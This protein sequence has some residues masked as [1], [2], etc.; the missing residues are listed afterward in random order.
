MKPSPTPK[1]QSRTRREQGIALV[2]VLAIL[3]LTAILVIAFFS[4]ARSEL[5]SS[6][7]Y[8]RGI[9]ASN[10]AKT[11]VDMVIHQIRSS[12]E[13]KGVAWASQPGMIRTWETTPKAGGNQCFKLYS[14]DK[15][16]IPE[17]D[18]FDDVGELKNWQN[19][20]RFV[21][22]NAPVIRTYDTKTEYFYPIID[23]RAA[24]GNTK[25]EGF[26]VDFSAVN[27][28]SNGKALPMPVRWIYQL[29]DGTLGTLAGSGKTGTFQP[30]QI[31]G[32]SLGG[33]PPSSQNPIVA[34]FAFWADDETCK[35]NVNTAAGG[36]AWDTPRAGG[37]SDRA[38]GMFQPVA[39]EFQRYPGHPATTSLIHVLFPGI[40]L[41]NS[42]R[43]DRTSAEAFYDLVPR[44]QR[45]GSV[46]GGYAGTDNRYGLILPI[47]PDQD[48]LYATIDEFI[49]R[50]PQAGMSD[51]KTGG[52]FKRQEQR[53]VGTWPDLRPQ[54]LSRFQFFLT[55]TS[56]APEVTIFNT[57]RISV[58]PS[59][60]GDPTSSTEPHFTTYD[61]RLRFCAEVGKRSA[62]APSDVRAPRDQSGRTPAMY[63]FQRF[64]SASTTADY[65]KIPRNQELYA[66][67]QVLMSSTVPGLDVSDGVTNFN[68]FKNKYGDRNRD[69]IITEIFD[70]IR[71][72]N[73]FDDLLM[74]Q[75]QLK[76]A[77]IP[78]APIAFRANKYYGYWAPAS[79]NDGTHESYTPGR[80]GVFQPEDLVNGHASSV[81]A[82]T[83]S[84]HGQVAPI[85]IASSAGQVT[86][87]FGRFFCFK[88]VGIAIIACAKDDGQAGGLARKAEGVLN[89]G[90]QVE[91][92]RT[93]DGATG[94]GDSPKPGW[95]LSN[96]CPLAAASPEAVIAAYGGFLKPN[97]AGP[98]QLS[99]L[100][101]ASTIVRN[102]PDMTGKEFYDY[103]SQPG[104]WNRSLEVGKPL[105]GGAMK[106]QAALLVS[107]FCP[108]KGWTL[109]NPDFRLRIDVK[110]PF[111]LDGKDLGIPTGP[112]L[113]KSTHVGLGG[114]RIWGGRNQGGILEP[115]M[116]MAGHCK[117]RNPG[118]VDRLAYSWMPRYAP[119][120]AALVEGGG[121]ICLDDPS[122]IF[123][124]NM[125]DPEEGPEALVYPWIGTPILIEGGKTDMALEGASLDL[126]IYPDG[127]ARTDGDDP[128][129]GRVGVENSG[130][131][132]YSQRLQLKFEDTKVPLPI[133]AGAAGGNRRE[134]PS[135]GMWKV[136]E[137]S[138]ARPARFWCWNRDGAFKGAP[139]Q[140]SY[141]WAQ[142]G[143]LS[144]IGNYQNTG[145]T[146]VADFADDGANIVRGCDVVR[147][148]LNAQGDDRLI[149]ATR[150]L[151]EKQFVHYRRSQNSEDGGYHDSGRLVA[152]NFSVESSNSGYGR[153]VK[154]PGI[155]GT[156]PPVR[157]SFVPDANPPASRRPQLPDQFDYKSDQWGDWDNGI[158]AELDGP[159]IN[160]P[161][162][163]NA[164]GVAYSDYEPKP[165]LT[166]SKKRP[167]IP[168]FT[169]SYV[170]ESAGPG[171]WSPNRIMP[172]PGMFGSLPTGV[173]PKSGTDPQPWQTLLFRRIGGSAQQSAKGESPRTGKV[174][175][176]WQHPRDHY[177]LD[178]FWMPVVEPYSISE[179]LATAGKVNMNYAIQPFDYI[180]RKSSLAGVFAS[181]ELL[182]VPNKLAFSAP[183]NTYKDGEGYGGNPTYDRTTD[184]GGNLRTISLRTWISLDETLRQFDNLFG[185]PRGNKPGQIFRTASQICE[186]WLVPGKPVQG[187]PYG[188]L[189]SLKLED[190]SQWY[191]ADKNPVAG[192]RSFGLVG[193]NARERP[194]TNLVA[195]LT[196]KSNTFNVHYRA[197]IIRQSPLSPTAPGQR[198]ADQEFAIYNSETDK[199]VGEYR[200]SSIVERYI[201]PNDVRIPDY[202]YLAG[203]GGLDLDAPGGAAVD[204]LDKYYRFR[205][206]SEKRFAP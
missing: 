180:K 158:A 156:E 47:Q 164:M 205:I 27:A 147:S 175:P 171:L 143:R 163:G 149:F 90:S 76:P 128:S 38:Y 9:E 63:H 50:A 155:P 26:D 57:P 202:A 31:P 3:T 45:G 79:K 46:G 189:N 2:T 135:A 44:I 188:P 174:H 15:M 43:Y 73:L 20:A 198:R 151:D 104:N 172:G 127:G 126:R 59:F 66:Y 96:V 193:D 60:Y 49:F 105:S 154:I 119:S 56:K 108:S 21:D 120:S 19:D 1:R 23:P 144:M 183:S 112:N 138:Q 85:R 30:L 89:R 100:S 130:V 148:Y 99:D 117:I 10:L 145:S 177:I 107:L 136:A 75:H 71:S 16:V 178:F 64:N 131:D 110:S 51:G 74:K 62:S 116:L 168:Y 139:P 41:P 169:D 140:K 35:L 129:T 153:T 146:D 87:G 197:Q 29:Q 17:S 48:R 133:L 113:I 93:I 195:R 55:A 98:L 186:Q 184:T 166:N 34:R 132:D 36:V 83:H 42:S 142:G 160:K 192:E 88:E 65:E 201:D 157:K 11:A 194:Y 150:E 176:G 185:G 33:S 181:E 122:Q 173:Y 141:G 40:A 109:L 7:V 8:H 39:N 18:V 206:V 106:V 91:T 187:N 25:V 61:R 5:A 159:Y 72:V 196:T 204:T 12:T 78:S 82:D 118:G 4:I 53:K 54:D 191:N 114:N 68:S 111:R 6:T 190:V 165:W 94:K 170:Q 81:G 115:R 32:K 97:G 123:G 101:N 92:W 58:W 199:M 52:A 167:Y 13:D 80:L 103:V 182:T 102:N 69:Q 124:N 152:A 95:D 67:L 121:A 22:L 86:T 203:H 24:I 37:V 200:G 84:G 14:D 134:E 162:E 137:E 28:S 179:P 77:N 161:D 70:Y 125:P